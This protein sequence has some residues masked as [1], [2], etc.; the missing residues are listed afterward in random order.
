MPAQC[1]LLGTDAEALGTLCPILEE[2]QIAVDVCSRRDAAV[3][4]LSQQKFELLVVDWES[5]DGPGH[6]L[7]STRLLATNRDTVV[8]ALVA[9]VDAMR[10]SQEMGAN[11]ILSK[12]ISEASAR[13]TIQACRVLFPQAA[14]RENR[15]PVHSL[16][17]VSLEQA[18]DAAILLNVSEGGMAIQAL[19]ALAKGQV[20]QFGIELPLAP[21]RVEARGEIMWA[22]PSGRAGVRF[23]EVPEPYRAQLRAWLEK[24]PEEAPASA[25]ITTAESLETYRFPWEKPPLG[26]RAAALAVDTGMVLAATSLFGLVFLVAPAPAL[27]ATAVLVTAALVATLGVSYL[28]MYRL[29]GVGTPGNVLVQR[30]TRK[31]PKMERSVELVPTEKLES[32]AKTP[33]QEPEPEPVLAGERADG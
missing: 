30:M 7:L 10:A 5:V 26:E 20:M 28:L 1:L 31:P 33:A 14:P 32:V 13:R 19:E 29:S 24:S 9:G 18:Q 15:R 25:V 23:V 21:V 12:P 3:Q 11:F 6:V 8:L 16:S 22:D 4:L 17:F 27:T 2:L